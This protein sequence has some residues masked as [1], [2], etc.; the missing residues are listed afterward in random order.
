MAK[1]HV[2]CNTASISKLRS[3]EIEKVTKRKRATC[4]SECFKVILNSERVKHVYF[5]VLN[6]HF[7]VYHE[8]AYCIYG[9]QKE[10]KTHQN[11][12]I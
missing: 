8:I 4:R 9:N 3:E 5:C 1:E 11:Q 12:V 10:K 6:F 2:E 7:R